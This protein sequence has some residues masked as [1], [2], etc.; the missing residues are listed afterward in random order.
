[1]PASPASTV[2][3]T[4]SV[5]TSPA[6]SSSVRAVEVEALGGD[7]Q[8]GALEALVADDQVGAAADDQQRGAGG[9]GLAD[10]V[11]HLGVG[12]RGDQPGRRGRRAGRWS[13]GR[14][15]RRGVPARAQEYGPL[16]ALGRTTDRGRVPAAATRRT[17]ASA[18]PVQHRPAVTRAAAVLGRPWA[19][20]SD[21]AR[22]SAR[23]RDRRGAAA[24]GD[25][26]GRQ[27]REGHRRR[28]DPERRDQAVDEGSG[29]SRSR[30]GR[31][32]PRP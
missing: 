2:R 31:R 1:M 17:R 6:A 29:R 19:A 18:A 22:G 16:T 14:G 10:G 21:R 7:A 26:Q 27:R 8:G 4:A 3:A 25:Q 24:A 5:H 12:R 30:P 32:R 9:V 15:G 11:D 23:V 13:G 28:A 20:V